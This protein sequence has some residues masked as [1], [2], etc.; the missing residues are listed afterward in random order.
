MI[1]LSRTRYSQRAHV[2]FAVVQTRSALLGFGESVV[3]VVVAHGQKLAMTGA[4]GVEAP[5]NF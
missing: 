2:F 1:A 3:M 4:I 5:G